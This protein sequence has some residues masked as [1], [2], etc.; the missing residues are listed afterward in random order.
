VYASLPNRKEWETALYFQEYNSLDQLR[1][2]RKSGSAELFEVLPS[3]AA[4]IE[5]LA[6]L[7]KYG[8][9]LR[10]KPVPDVDFPSFDEAL[11]KREVSLMRYAKS[12]R[13]SPK[14]MRFGPRW[15]RSLSLAWLGFTAEE[16]IYINELFRMIGIF[17]VST[18]SSLNLLFRRLTLVFKK[19]G[20]L[21]TEGTP[22]EQEDGWMKLVN[23][24]AG[25]GYLQ[26]KSIETFHESIVDWVTGEVEHYSW[27]QTTG[28]TS[29]QFYSDF[30]NGVK[31]FLKDLPGLV[32]ANKYAKTIE[33]WSS[34]I[35]YWARSGATKRRE[36]VRYYV[37]GKTRYAKGS[38]WR[39]ALALRPTTI[40]RVLSG[41][42]HI[43]QK[44][45]AVQKVE[46]GKVRAVVNSDDETYWLMAY[47][48]HWIERAL[49]GTTKSTLFM[50]VKQLAE[51]W[52]N[53]AKDTDIPWT[54]KI[55][56]DQDHFDHQVNRKMIDIMVEEIS[57]VVSKR[58]EDPVRTELLHVLARIRRTL[59]VGGYVR[60]GKEK[61]RISK[62]IMSGWRWT[63]LLDTISNWAE[64]YTAAKII[65]RLGGSYPYLNVVAQ[66]DDDRVLC[67]DWMSAGMVYLAYKMMGFG[68]NP[69]KFFV[70]NKRDEYLRRVARPGLVTGYYFRSITSILWRNPGSRDPVA[71]IERLSEIARGWNTFIS[72]GFPLKKG[73]QQYLNDATGGSRIPREVIQEITNTPASLGGLGY[74]NSGRIKYTPGKYTRQYAIEKEDIKGLRKLNERWKRIA[75]F[76]DEQGYRQ[77]M[78]ENLDLPHAKK[79]IT[80]GE[81]ERYAKPI[82]AFQGYLRNG[83]VPYVCPSNDKLPLTGKDVVLRQAI[84][85]RDLDWIRNVYVDPEWRVISRR[86]EQRGGRRVWFGWLTGDLPFKPPNIWGYSSAYISAYYDDVARAGM[87]E[88]I[89]LQSFSMR[90]VYRICM[91]VENTTRDRVLKVPIRVAD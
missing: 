33:E 68:V 17:Q 36:G 88:L 46:T 83:N 15:G 10:A 1:A 38:K 16:R 21:L 34:D 72:R 53:F 77:T 49:E 80:V 12:W 41:H 81:Y 25:G 64:I 40:E 79:E 71:G 76:F 74:G 30:R 84:R 58:A 37:D 62:G 56:L 91:L 6:D 57:V 67:P 55:P 66:G 7:I 9:E 3:K 89:M 35:S 11:T 44:N 19:Y 29:S 22:L 47:V 39:T 73:L 32:K 28:L 59:T 20:N 27:N 69:G 51:M 65:T 54:V 23:W 31:D 45:S 5:A 85:V 42:R 87:T 48:S 52:L 13:P 63:A 26:E 43:E 82:Y 24:E 86:I 14:W 2:W 61:I 70:D 8:K 90:T 50:N 4:A 75:P 78:V 60:V 18:A